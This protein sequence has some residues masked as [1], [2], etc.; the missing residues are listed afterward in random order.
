MST[1]AD[2]QD[3]KIDILAFQLNDNRTQL[4]QTLAKDNS[5]GNICT[6]IQKLAQRWV[7]E[8][9]T[10]AGSVPYKPSLGT[11]FTDQVRR[12]L[13]KNN[14]D[15]VSYFSA[16]AL[17]V[18]INLKKEDQ[19]TDPADERLDRATLDGF[20]FDNSGKLILNVTVL[21]A[22]GTSRKVIMPISVTTGLI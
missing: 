9:L 11:P 12:G 7:L 18:E 2:Y 21:S 14:F 1:V 6:G 3:R 17:I 5:G 10:P 8:F 4:S 15:I 16:S 22:A 20:S 13:L 19:S